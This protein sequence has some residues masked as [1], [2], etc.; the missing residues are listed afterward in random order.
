MWYELLSI[1][2]WTYV[3]CVS[4]EHYHVKVESSQA[5]KGLPQLFSSAKLKKAVAGKENR[6]HFYFV[7]ETKAGTLGSS[8]LF[9]C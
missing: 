5:N 8:L 6:A 9:T 7:D 2:S 1:Y 3:L 4:S